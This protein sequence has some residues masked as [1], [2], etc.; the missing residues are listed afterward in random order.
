LELSSL[1]LY[2][3]KPAQ[4]TSFLR[5]LSLL[6][7]AACVLTGCP[8]GAPLDN[9]EE[10]N[11]ARYEP[12][13]DDCID[14]LLPLRCGTEGCHGAGEDGTVAGGVDL[15]LPDAESRVYNLPATYPGLT[16]CPS[17]PELL[18]NSANVSASLMLT[19]IYGTHSCGDGMPVPRI[20]KAL[21][22]EELVCYENW[23]QSMADE[24]A[25]P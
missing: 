17:P 13:R 16:G 14:D 5:R 25:S 9:A 3:I 19:K 24:G 8:L 21:K 20:V 12:P 7:T 22:G 18:V 15:N 11:V 23:I 10:Q 1:T 6:A 4:Q 2:R